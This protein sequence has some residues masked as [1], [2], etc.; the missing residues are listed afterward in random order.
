MT[1]IAEILTADHAPIPAAY[2]TKHHPENDRHNRTGKMNQTLWSPT[3]VGYILEKREYMGHT[4]L[5]KTISVDY[6]TKKRRKA[7]PDELLIFKN[8]HEAIVDEETWN[9]AQ[10]LR[11]TV[12]RS[13]K[14]G[15]VSNPLTSILYCADCGAKFTYRE[16][17]DNKEKKYDQRLFLCLPALP[18]P[19]RKMHA[20]LHQALRD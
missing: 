4:V 16:P 11:K 9:T 1:Q 17:A 15:K 19:H 18:T 2:E 20:A 12:R 8:T 14:Y 13:P 7:K 5:G 6:K 10:R 3:T